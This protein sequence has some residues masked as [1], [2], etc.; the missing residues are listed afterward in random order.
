MEFPE[1]VIQIAIEPKTKGDQEK[2]GHR[3]QPPCGRR[4]R[5]SASSPT[6]RSGQTIIAGM[7]EL[8][9]DILVD[10]MKREFKVEANVGQPRRWPIARRSR[11][12]AESR[13]HPQETVGWFGPVRPRQDRSL[14][15]WIP[16]GEDFEFVSKIVGGNVPKEYIPGV[17]KG[18]RERPGRPVRDGRFPDA[19]CEGDPDRRCLPRRGLLGPGLR[20]RGPCRVPRGCAGKAGAQSCSSPIMKVEVVTPDETTLATVIG[21]LN[22]RRGQI[23]GQEMPAARDRGHQRPWCRWPTCS[24]TWTTVCA[25]CPKDGPNTPCSSITTRQVP[26]NVAQEIQEQ[27][28]LTCELETKLN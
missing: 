18:I 21:D 12:E 4:T 1:P 6:R 8:H 3:A 25:R 7:G 15:R 16:S 5:P 10:R 9:L 2:D 24:A 13:L 28:R 17:Q 23:Q 22:S 11:R 20:D 26:S 19:R 27:I 14:N